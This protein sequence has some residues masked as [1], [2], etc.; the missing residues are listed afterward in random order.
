MKNRTNAARWANHMLRLGQARCTI[1][2][3]AVKKHTAAITVTASGT[4]PFET[5]SQIRSTPN[6]TRRAANRI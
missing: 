3:I 5:M 4:L 2:A 6:G 1:S